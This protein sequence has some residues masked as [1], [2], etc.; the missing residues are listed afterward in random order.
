[1]IRGDFDQFTLKIQDNNSIEAILT[2]PGSKGR[3]EKGKVV[4]DEYLLQ[5][6]NDGIYELSEGQ[7]NGRT[8]AIQRVG[9]DL[10][11]ALFPDKIGEAF[12]QALNKLKSSK[13]RSLR[14]VI[15]IDPASFVSKW[16]LEFLY[17]PNADYWL[18]A[19]KPGF[20]LSRRI[21]FTGEIPALEDAGTSDS[22]SLRVLIVV[23]KPSDLG[24]V[25]TTR[26]LE[27]I[28][29]LTQSKS[30]S[31]TGQESRQPLAKNIDVKVIGR[32]EN[33]ERVSGI[34][35]LDQPASYRK[36]RELVGGELTGVAW[37]PHV[38]HFIGHGKA[39]QR[40]EACLGLVDE[41][42]GGV[43]WCTADEMSK[44]FTAD[45]QPRLVV[46]QAC[47]SAMP[48]TESG[49]MSMAAHLFQRKIHAIVAM[50]FKIDNAI[51]TTFAAAFY[52]A[53]RRGE[54]VDEAVQYGRWK[55][56]NDFR[57][58]D[59]YFGAPVLFA[60]SPEGIM[61]PVTKPYVVGRFSPQG[62]S[63]PEEVTREQRPI[64]RTD[65][66]RQ[67]LQH[68]MDWLEGAKFPINEDQA[69]E[70]MR[71][72]SAALQ[73]ERPTETQVVSDALE[74]LDGGDPAGARRMLQIAHRQLDR[75]AIV[76]AP[77]EV[78]SVAQRIRKDFERTFENIPDQLK[79]QVAPL[80]TTGISGPT[81]W[82]SESERQE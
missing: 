49:F 20:A 77:I 6:I 23:S 61:Q 27:G 37:K 39:A 34:D 75:V 66:G 80:P 71:K 81:T 74:C 41:R 48:A 70:W 17:C 47:E 28:A 59:P 15:E 8:R 21:I 57:W 9:R 30:P 3:L 64:A 26:V 4:D 50:Q 12:E 7:L 60:F 54:D 35:Y 31:D 33:Y 16:P 46:L 65:Q 10:Y 2:I 82:K 22:S 67:A 11:R 32:L 69:R 18:A 62:P 40:R 5:D 76:S 25:I 44:L 79:S 56:S 53:L 78:D 63:P 55:I 38:L 19:E 52:D 45:W 36:I 43:D 72:A 68:A 24:G 51:A 14:M 73:D 42:T 29:K 1:M 13:D 58:K